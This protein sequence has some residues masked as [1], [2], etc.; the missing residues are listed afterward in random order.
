MGIRGALLR[1]I[2]WQRLLNSPAGRWH[3]SFSTITPQLPNVS[4][5]P[6]QSLPDILVITCRSG[7]STISTLTITM[8]DR[9]LDARHLSHP[10][11]S[12]DFD[13]NEE[14]VYQSMPNGLNPMLR[15][16][17]PFH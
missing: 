14:K 7:K 8:L 12:S 13:W 6:P 2:F 10:S 3:G 9:R 16:G 1:M 17:S 11:A 5:S 4:P 15:K